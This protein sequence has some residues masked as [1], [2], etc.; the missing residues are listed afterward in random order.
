M[1]I[2]SYKKL[3]NGKY[4]L[5]LDNL[6]RLEVYEDVILKLELLIKK[7]I[8]KDI[9]KKINIENEKYDCYYTALKYLK[10]RVRSQKE[11]YEYLLKK[12]F[13]NENIIST[14]EI[15]NK[16]GYINDYNF[17]KSFLNN[18][19]ITTS[20]GPYKIKNDLKE[21]GISSDIIEDILNDYTFDIQKEKISKQINRMVKSNRNRGNNLLKKKMFNDLIK[22]GFKRSIVADLL[23]ELQLEDDKE[24]LEKEYNKLYN[25]LSKKYQGDELEYYIRQKLYQKGFE[26]FQ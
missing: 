4:Q 7:D 6:E 1:K 10:V 22:Q 2:K 12:D 21:K 19:L 14:I 25:K 24:L 8:T 20:N 5:V 13:S 3:K 18:K 16:Q 23:Q 9:R 26:S 15:L 11:I 17:A